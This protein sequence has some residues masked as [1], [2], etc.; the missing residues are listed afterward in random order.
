[1]NGLGVP[2]E[3]FFGSL[4]EAPCDQLNGVSVRHALQTLGTDWGRHHM[5][6][7]FWTGLWRNKV[8]DFR[9]CG[10]EKIVVDDARFVNEFHLIKSMGGYIIKIERP[11]VEE[12]NHAS[13]QDYKD[14][15]PDGLLVNSTDTNG[16]MEAIHLMLSRLREHG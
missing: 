2:Y 5:G 3:N 16:F 1:M 11:E 9:S 6:Q 12:M 10:Q 13:E 8:E 7:D 4:K 15:T 14:W